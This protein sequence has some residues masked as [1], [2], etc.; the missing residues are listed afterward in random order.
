MCAGI[1]IVPS[2]QSLNGMEYEVANGARIPNTGEKK[3]VGISNEGISRRLAAQVCAAN[4]GLLSVSKVTGT[5][6]RVVF[7]TD[8]SY[9]EDKETLERMYL[10]ERNGMYMLKMWTRKGL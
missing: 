7:D 4:K 9:I 8:G 10:H 6:S 3:F 5:G 2:M 1:P